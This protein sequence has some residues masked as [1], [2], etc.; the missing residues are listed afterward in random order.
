MPQENLQISLKKN[1]KHKRNASK[2]QISDMDYSQF[3]QNSYQTDLDVE[4]SLPP[5]LK[6]RLQDLFFQ[7]EKEFEALYLENIT[8][9]EKIE[10]LHDRFDKEGLTNEKLPS[11]NTDV[12]SVSTSV[13]SSSKQKL[14]SQ[15][16]LKTTHKLKA[17]TSKIV[18]SFKTPSLNC[19]MVREFSGHKDG[20][21]DVG[22]AQNGQPLIGTASAG[23]FYIGEIISALI[24]TSVTK[25][26]FLLFQITLL[27]FGIQKLASVC[28]SIPDTPVQLIR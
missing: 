20:I 13:R 26:N 1:S 14:S 24:N 15:Q 23:E 3:L 11:E 17:Q 21:W 8:L 27:E 2:L 19:S 5:T 18:S 10:K 28:S 25:Q 7:I 16:K 12:E 22:V 9:Q 4:S 6:T